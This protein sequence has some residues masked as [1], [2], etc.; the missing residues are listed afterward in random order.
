MRHRKLNRLSKVDGLGLVNLY[1]WESEFGRTESGILFR[2]I[3][4]GTV[5]CFVLF[6]DIFL[7][8]GLQVRVKEAYQKEDWLTNLFFE[9]I[10]CRSLR[11]Y[12]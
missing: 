9:R 3:Y 12:S 4:P 10:G 7:F 1:S 8:S 6:G 11:Y 2:I 5:T